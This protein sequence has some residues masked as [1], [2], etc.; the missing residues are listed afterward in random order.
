M[1]TTM[2][3]RLPM[4]K[5]EPTPVSPEHRALFARFEAEFDHD[6]EFCGRHQPLVR[7]FDAP[8]ADGRRPVDRQHRLGGGLIDLTVSV[9]PLAAAAA[10]GVH[11]VLLILAHLLVTVVPTTMFG[12]TFGKYVVGT[13]VVDPTTLR[14]PSFGR[15]LVRWA[16]SF[17]PIAA[18]LAVGLP[19]DGA[20]LLSAAVYCLIA[21][22]LRG[23][24]DRLGRTVVVG[25]CPG[26]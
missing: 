8:L 5:F 12:F 19:I 23:L 17:A 25:R 1:T 21:V 18:A 4:A 15:A 3:P 16:L 26:R 13:R 20:V 24:H 9:A 6:P 10:A 2:F 14:A 22:D 7:Q 11:P